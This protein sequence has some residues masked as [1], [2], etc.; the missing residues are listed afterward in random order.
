MYTSR[1]PAGTPWQS[2]A[3]K[4]ELGSQEAPATLPAVATSAEWDTCTWEREELS[5]KSMNTAGRMWTWLLL[6]LTHG[7]AS[8]KVSFGFAAGQAYT[9]QSVLTFF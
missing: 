6:G 7:G 8:P 4:W 3:I 5:L 1:V 9:T 2:E